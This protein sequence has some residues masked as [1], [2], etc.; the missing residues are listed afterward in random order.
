LFSQYWILF[1]SNPLLNFKIFWKSN[2]F[3]VREKEAISLGLPTF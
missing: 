2:L 1:F 3:G